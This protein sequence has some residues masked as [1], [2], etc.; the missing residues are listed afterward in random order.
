[1]RKDL[2]LLWLTEGETLSLF[3]ESPR[4]WANKVNHKGRVS[5]SMGVFVSFG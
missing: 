5:H 1:M 2:V 3:V 4:V